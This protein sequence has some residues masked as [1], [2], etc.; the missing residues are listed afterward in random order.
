MKH[1]NTMKTK[2]I[3]KILALLAIITL[4]G[5]IAYWIIS[6]FAFGFSIML[7]LAIAS[8]IMIYII[9]QRYKKS[10]QEINNE[11]L[12]SFYR[13]IV[14]INGVVAIIAMCYYFYP[15]Q[16]VYTNND[17]HAFVVEG[18]K[19]DASS[20]LLAADDKNAFFDNTDLAGRMTLTNIN[21]QDGTATLRIDN[22][23]MPL[24]KIVYGDWKSNKKHD[25]SFYEMVEGQDF[26][27]SFYEEDSIF[28]INK[29]NVAVASLKVDYDKEYKHW[30]SIKPQFKARYKI[31]YTDANGNKRCDISAFNGI[32]KK[33]YSIGDL[34]PHLDV[35][36][37]VC[38]SEI[39]LMRGKTK[40]KNVNSND[41]NYLIKAPL[42]VGYR[43]GSGLYAVRSENGT[44][45]T[46]TTTHIN[47]PL[48]GSVYKIGLDNHMADFILKS[49]TTGTG[50]LALSYNMPQYRYLNI[51]T[52]D[53][54]DDFYTFT[55]TSSIIDANGDLDI[56]HLSENILLYDLFYHDNNVYQMNPI[57]F[58]IHP[59]H[60]LKPLELSIFNTVG[61]NYGKTYRAG[62]T[63][64]EIATSLPNA[65][66]MVRLDNFKDHNLTR[67][68]RINGPHDSQ[69]MLIIIAIM[70]LAFCVL[71]SLRSNFTITYI[72]PMAYIALI[73]LMAI[74]L[75]LIWRASVFP[76]VE[77]ITIYEFNK[78]HTNE[79]WPLLLLCAFV[80]VVLIS[81]TNFII[82]NEIYEHGKIYEHIAKINKRVQSKINNVYYKILGSKLDEGRLNSLIYYSKWAFLLVIPYVLCLVAG[83]LTRAPMLCVGAP[84]LLYF[85]VDFIINHQFGLYNSDGTFNTN[86]GYFW[87]SLIN[88]MVAS[89]VMVRLDGGYGSLFI[90]F[91]MLSI[92]SRLFDIYGADPRENNP[93][94]GVSFWGTMILSVIIVIIIAFIRP[95][96]VNL[97]LGSTGFLV[98]ASIIFAGIIFLLIWTFW[99]L[100]GKKLWCISCAVALAFG[101]IFFGLVFWGKGNVT[102]K[103]I[104]NRMMVLADGPSKVLGETTSQ[105]NVQKFL[106]AS[107]NDWVLEEYENRGKSIASVLGEKGYG[108]FKIQPHS[109]VGV[110]W[111]TQLTDLSVSRLVIAEHSRLIPC[112]IILLFGGMFFFALW[113]PTNRRWTRNLLIQ[114]PLL[115]LVQS[116]IVWMA[117]TRR[118]VFIGQ[119]FPMLSIISKT[120]FT[121]CIIGFIVWVT[122]AIYESKAIEYDKGRNLADTHEQTADYYRKISKIFCYTL[123][124]ASGLIFLFGQ[125]TRHEKFE[126]NEYDV[127]LCMQATWNLIANPQ[128]DAKSIQ[129]LFEEFQ[130][131]LIAREN[132][133]IVD[134]NLKIYDITKVYDQHTILEKF[135]QYYGYNPNGQSSDT[136]AIAKVFVP[137]TSDSLYSNFAHMVFDD[138]INKG[139][140]KND[141]NDIVY[142]FKSRFKN[143]AKQKENVRYSFGVTN[144]YYR[145]RLPSR[146]S[147]SW[148]GSLVGSSYV[149]A[150]RVSR[151]K[152][153]GMRIYVLPK[154]WTKQKG[155]SVIVQP[156]S[157]DLTVVGKHAP[158]KLH[159]GES[160]YLDAYEMILGTNKTNL[161][162]YGVS[163]Y[164]A[165]RAIINSRPQFI[166]PM[167]NS[168]YWARPFGDQ[169]ERWAKSGLVK[170]KKSEY[171]TKQQEDIVV[172][173][174][175]NLTMDLHR[176][177]DQQARNANVA[178]VV[179]DGDGRVLAL[180]DHK[181]PIYRLNPN[182]VQRIKGIEDSVKLEG[183][184]GRIAEQ[185]FGNRAIL[186][187]NNGPGSSQKPLVWTAVT[188]K[189]PQ[190]DWNSLKIKAISKKM[191]TVRIDRKDNYVTYSYGRTLICNE[192]TK[193]N[194]YKFKSIKD[195]EGNG[196]KDI[197]VDY[198]MYKSSNFYNAAMVYIGSH[199]S[200]M[201]ADYNN[202]FEK[203][204]SGDADEDM[205][206]I[207]KYNKKSYS[208]SHPLTD[209]IV[210]NDNAPLISGLRD[211]FKLHINK[212]DQRNT[213]LHPS[214][215]Y[216]TNFVD[217]YFA[218]P[219]VSYFNNTMRRKTD[220]YSIG[221]EA[222]KSTAIGKNSVWLVSPLAMAEMY[223]RMISLNKNYSLTLD[224]DREQPL[225]EPFDVD[226]G[227]D[228][229][230]EMRNKL[231][232]PGLN[233]VFLDSDG[234]ASGVYNKIN[235][236]IQGYYIYGKTGTI[237]G[238]IFDEEGK[239]IEEQDH[240]LAVVITN[241]DISKLK[242]EDYKDMRFIIAYIADFNY[243]KDGNTWRT[244]DSEIIK[245]ILQS[246][247]FKN[248]MKGG[249]K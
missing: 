6:N 66:W 96:I 225:Y 220:T 169:I 195:D 171:R 229:Y 180:V 53:D 176:S 79:T 157:N 75:M 237:D 203:A 146:I 170:C 233:K 57:F 64:P 197:T 133:R 9:H 88:M 147:D 112:L 109:N 123:A 38:L 11:Q 182:D 60:T 119:D 42:L 161:Q 137:T 47:I 5:L 40:V 159:K 228:A 186:S 122:T 207:I 94:N 49:D 179:A 162:K 51:K 36:D 104:F 80:V 191:P 71:L 45:Y 209:E 150:D 194:K 30:Y 156:S 111:S 106:N 32:I 127:S 17:H 58:S 222:I 15:P 65:K 148:M 236:Y 74:R 152:E 240:L 14:L 193:D 178:V 174:S 144:K 173:I 22:S 234:T 13:A 85:G 99:T 26:L 46:R 20:M 19:T 154:G 230:I 48:K 29:N 44:T 86:H 59:D 7:L 243:S 202:I 138:F 249:E 55:V 12:M 91:C 63:L 27:H 231:F 3:Y 50:Y 199:P 172:T 163:N 62:D 246:D 167:Q 33:Y 108:Y 139:S 160:F 1:H 155:M 31:Y 128:K 214:M 82:I 153:K 238:T 248:Y 110:S 177:I 124:S 89:L 185:F 241:K 181:K 34:Y 126:R 212:Y 84:V 143:E 87:F 35:I 28:L 98:F 140:Y 10:K 129:K 83:L 149:N 235:N 205:F 130:D 211:N 136:N 95:I 188:T 166:Y 134:K 184:R 69:K 105:I 198:Y 70:T 120:N 206:P 132:K 81:K 226:G 221:R 54:K 189:L 92:I 113:F 107:L 219:E 24:Y 242:P 244:T 8:I 93:K 90:V 164:I 210:N 115:F 68:S 142:L 118:F 224:P 204:K 4:V 72:E 2:R 61:N 165:R 114:I 78:W 218:L 201:L 41:Y 52:D 77:H 216:D 131:T 196:I 215:Y 73:S 190:W 151:Y 67:P 116:L 239:E 37:G 247:E 121:M 43:K 213:S 97:F 25:D 101:I 208:F 102:D 135:C 200:G 158:H 145:H 217:V 39:V 23:G 125:A 192:N 183:I 168:F 245:T 16:K 56:N 76:P 175:T 100:V 187:L 141:I 103:P 21:N 232:V 18:I 223:G 227:I 117:V